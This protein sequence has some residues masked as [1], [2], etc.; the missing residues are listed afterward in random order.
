MIYS[1][2]FDA[3]PAN[4]LAAI[5]QRMWGVL[6]GQDKD[7]RYARL[8]ANDRQAVIDILRETKSDLPPEFSEVK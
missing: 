4:A 6:S 8:A 3:L 2:G 7:P 1:D 5:Y